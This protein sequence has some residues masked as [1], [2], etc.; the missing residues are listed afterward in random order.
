MI[1]SAL[2]PLLV[3]FILAILPASTAAQ[4]D[5]SGYVR[6][7]R[8]LE[9][10]T[11]ANVIL[12]GL[13]KGTSTDAD[14]FFRIGGMLPSRVKVQISHIG[15]GD[16]LL[17]LPLSGFKNL[18]VLLEADS[19]QM[20]SVVVTASRISQSISDIPQRVEK[21]DGQTIESYPATNT[22]NLLKMI[23]GINVNR[24]WGIFSRNAS[25]TMRGMPGSSRSLILLDGVPLNKT[26]GGTVSWHLVTP[27]EIDRI[28]VVKGPGSTIYGNN[29]MGGVINIL[30]KQP[31]KTFAGF[32]DI[33]YGTYNT[34]KGQVNV[35]GNHLKEAKGFFWRFG[36]FYRQGDGYILEPGEIRDSINTEAYLFEGNANGLLGYRFSANSKV[37][38]DFRHY[39]DKRGSGVKVYAD[40]GS[41]ESFSNNNLMMAYEGKAGRFTLNAKAFY[42]NE[43]Y[44][45]QNENL[46]SS[47][48]YKLVDTETNKDDYGLW[49]TMAGTLGRAHRFTTGLDLKNG[50]LDNREVYRTSTDDIR[51]RGNLLFTA[52]F[53]QDEISL[54]EGRFKV[55]AGLR[56][57]H[58]LY[59]NGQLD[60][61]DPTGKTGFP[62]AYTETFPEGSWVRLS[63]KLALNYQVTPHLRSFLSASTGFM[64]PRLD[65]LAGSRKIRRGFKTANP[66]LV[67]ETLWTIEWGVDWTA[68][69]K[70]EIKPSVFYSRGDDFQ[71]LVATGDYIDSASEDP[72]PVYQR[73]N[74]SKVEVAGGE[75]GIRY[76]FTPRLVINAAYTYNYSKILDY[77]STGETDLAGKYLNEVPENIVF[78][79]LSWK[80][81]VIDLFIDYSFTD[82]QW[83]DEENTEIIERYSV[84]NVRLSR[85]IVKGLMASLDIQDLLDEQFIDRKGYLSPGR[86][87]MFG[88]RYAINQ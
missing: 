54:M 31:K 74:V 38:V 72:V 26:A 75:L 88:I 65:D 7:S 71:Y 30:T 22:D 28:E 69:E 21:I 68:F 55:V 37:E 58:A 11:G 5:I 48:E 63:P 25:V 2:I 12:P 73:Q 29:A 43:G 1:K 19:V 33:G 20:E 77:Q 60:V 53:L 23:P 3:C 10:L 8:T 62:D 34:F 61:K 4:E 86:F 24:S 51:T 6:D 84:V 67:P 40:D 27:E 45:R 17:S 9:P 44:F 36:G 52:L 82:E 18:T 47:G 42:F 14:G 41:Y 83:Y 64:P 13:R 57:D 16:T 50:S 39:Q 80:N 85:K 76:P 70:L 78:I 56:L 49:I 66:D 35:S 59:Y 79:G 32:A 81:R 46:N 15:Y 87:I